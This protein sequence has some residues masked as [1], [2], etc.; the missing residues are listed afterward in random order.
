MIMNNET[1]KNASHT[2]PVINSPTKRSWQSPEIEE[3]DYAETE[4]HFTGSGA[5][6][7]TYS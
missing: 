7:G 3:V 5:D 4:A 2:E 6:G 1:E